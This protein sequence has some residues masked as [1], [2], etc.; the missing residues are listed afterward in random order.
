MDVEVLV[1]VEEE[2]EEVEVKVSITSLPYQ[3]HPINEEGRI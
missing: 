3:S 2:G 1:V